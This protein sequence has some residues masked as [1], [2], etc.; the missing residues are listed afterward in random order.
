MSQ[1]FKKFEILIIYDSKDEE[2]LSYINNAIKNYK[3][4]TLI[5]NK[6]IKGLIYSISTS[7]LK[8]KGKYI[9]FLQ[10]LI[11]LILTYNFLRITYTL[12]IR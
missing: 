12:K 3:F 2:N 6:D 1:N 4:I 9:L 8:C 10:P 7:I 11:N 5:N